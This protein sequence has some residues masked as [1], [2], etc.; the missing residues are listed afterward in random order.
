MDSAVRADASGE[1]AVPPRAALA[2]KDARTLARE[3]L[4]MT[5]EEFCAAFRARR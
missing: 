5:Q 3:L 4:G 1:L 2:G